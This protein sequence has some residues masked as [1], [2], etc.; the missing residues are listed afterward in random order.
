MIY[1]MYYRIC[2]WQRCS[3]VFLFMLMAGFAHA[4]NQSFE[5]RGVV[6]DSV[7]HLPI[8]NVTIAFMGKNAV[9]STDAQGQFL[10]KD[11]HINDHLVLTSVGFDRKTVQVTSTNRMTIYLSSSS[12][13]LDEVTVV[14]YG[15][16]KKK[17]A[18]WP[19]LPRSTRKKLRDQHQSDLHAGGS[20]SWTNCLPAK[21]GTR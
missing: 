9:V 3:L 13:N 5:L 10:I 20:G 7:G 11:A 2:K 15:T 1:H 8:S 21:W 12:S 6:L 18:W 19:P 16:Q 14:A 17:R 4:Q